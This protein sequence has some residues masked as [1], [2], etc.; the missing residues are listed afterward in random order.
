MTDGMTR[1][2]MLTRGRGM[3]KENRRIVRRV[4]WK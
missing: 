3:T 2:A 1:E 4:E